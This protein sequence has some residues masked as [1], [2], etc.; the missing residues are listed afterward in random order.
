MH[1]KYAPFDL[2]LLLLFICSTCLLGCVRCRKS[3]SKETFRH[4]NGSI[5][6]DLHNPDPAKPYVGT[7][8]L[9]LSFSCT[10]FAQKIEKIEIFEKFATHP[11]VN[12]TSYLIQ[13]LHLLYQKKKQKKEKKYAKQSKCKI[14][15][16]S[17]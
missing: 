7:F 13:H 9:F 11:S 6:C 8:L 16:F 3:L 17:I 15:N 10:T 14:Y 2:S 12:Q 5:Y 1:N 4:Y